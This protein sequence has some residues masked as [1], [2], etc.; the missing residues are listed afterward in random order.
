MGQ[1]TTNLITLLLNKKRRK[2]RTNKIKLKNEENNSGEIKSFTSID[3]I[4]NH[5][6]NKSL[7]SVNTPSLLINNNHTNMDL[8]KKFSLNIIKEENSINNKNKIMDLK[9]KSKIPFP[10]FSRNKRY[11]IG[12]LQLKD[13]LINF[14]KTIKYNNKENRSNSFVN[15]NEKHNSINPNVYFSHKSNNKKSLDRNNLYAEKFIIKPTLNIESSPKNKFL[16]LIK[17]RS[18]NKKLFNSSQHEIKDKIDNIMK[19]KFNLNNNKK[20]NE[21]KPNNNNF[22]G[23]SADNNAPN[24]INNQN[25]WEGVKLYDK[26]FALNEF[27]R[28]KSQKK[29]GK[30]NYKRNSRISRSQKSSSDNKNSILDNI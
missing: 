18:L 10:N 30:I 24:F 6:S 11:S 9:N 28:K 26:D 8:D 5:N 17:A 13:A 14:S 7:S 29:L 23:S 19:N 22:S 27:K 3:N 12:K 16:P 25:M 21:V 1:I 2:S 4:N 20:A 15:D